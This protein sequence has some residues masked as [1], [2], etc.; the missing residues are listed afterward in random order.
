MFPLPHTAVWLQISGASLLSVPDIAAQAFGEASEHVYNDYDGLA[1]ITALIHQTPS[2]AADQAVLGLTDELASTKH[3]VRLAILFPPIIYGRGRGL[4]HHRSVQIPALC[5][6]AVREGVAAHVG[7]GEARWGN[8]HIADLS[9]LIVRLVD[10][11][12]SGAPVQ[13]QVW[14]QNGLYFVRDGEI[15]RLTATTWPCKRR[16]KKKERKNHP[17]PEVLDH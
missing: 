10:K 15:V 12:V 13:D 3:G 6:L 4:G 1:D 5:Q 14:N 7:K 8:V 9:G 11:A 16:W 2:R 17:N